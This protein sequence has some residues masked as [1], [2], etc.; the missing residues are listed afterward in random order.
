MARDY[1][2]KHTPNKRASRRQHRE[3]EEARANEHG[4]PLTPLKV[5][6]SVILAILLML[7]VLGVY[8]VIDHFMSK[9]VQS[10]V[11][12][13]PEGSVQEEA[14]VKAQTSVEVETVAPILSEPEQA[15]TV[16]VIE[17]A[18]KETSHDTGMTIQAMPNPQSLEREVLDFE[19]YDAL[20]SLEVDADVEVLSVQLGVPHYLIAGSFR[21]RYLAQREQQRLAQYGLNLYI[22]ESTYRDRPIF[23]LKTK[24]YTDRLDMNAMRNK[25]RSRGAQVLV[26]KKK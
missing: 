6:L 16:S 23:Y 4:R 19:F 1:R 18:P 20:G 15:N 9:A 2:Y 3:E 14:S 11:E 8:F 12:S 5:L 10:T 21:E 24:Y 17:P 25:L 22:S 26:L 13:V 7:S